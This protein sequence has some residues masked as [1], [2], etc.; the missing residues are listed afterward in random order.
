MNSFLVTVKIFFWEKNQKMA[1]TPREIDLRTVVCEQLFTGHLFADNYS[2]DLFSQAMLSA[3]SVVRQTVSLC[4]RTISR[5]T[6]NW[7]HG[8]AEFLSCN[9]PIIWKFIH[10][11]KVEQ[12]K[13]DVFVERSLAGQQLSL[14]RKN[15][16]DC[17][18]S[19]PITHIVAQCGQID[20]VVYLCGLAHNFNF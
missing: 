15:Y 14:G 16:H 13:N 1:Q 11:L 19:R 5:S 18:L 17:A 4:A 8:F 12:E 20:I 3:A 2:Q 7:R 9:H 10:A 6:V